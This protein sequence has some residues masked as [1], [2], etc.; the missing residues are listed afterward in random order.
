MQQSRP[1]ARD[2]MSVEA[3]Q[4]TRL[5][6]KLLRARIDAD[7]YWQANERGEGPFRR[8]PYANPY[9]IVV[10]NGL[11]CKRQFTF[12]SFLEH[13]T[14]RKAVLLVNREDASTLLLRIDID[15]EE[16]S[17]LDA[18]ELGHRINKRFLFGKGFVCRSRGNGAGV[19]FLLDLRRI[20]ACARTG[21]IR[22][23]GKR[24]AEHCRGCPMLLMW[25]R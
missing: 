23:M 4:E 20:A 2:L 12:R 25:K 13:L 11:R 17:A 18:L 15:S 1:Q 3:Q 8:N 14:T 6:W 5:L 10:K 7:D 22:R 16:G 21:V 19:Y 9:P 24:L